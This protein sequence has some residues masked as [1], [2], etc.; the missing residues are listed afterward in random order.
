MQLRRALHDP[1]NFAWQNLALPALTQARCGLAYCIA[2]TILLPIAVTASSAL[3][4]PQFCVRQVGCL[5]FL[6]AGPLFSA[7]LIVTGPWAQKLVD[8]HE[9][10]TYTAKGDVLEGK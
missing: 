3:M 4:G 7:S 10:V 1:E 2:G 9:N 8:D 5:V 6:A